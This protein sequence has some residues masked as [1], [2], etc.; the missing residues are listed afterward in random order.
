[1]HSWL[2]NNEH[3]KVE[4]DKHVKGLIRFSKEAIMFG[5]IHD[6][7]RIDDQGNIEALGKKT[8]ASL[9]SD[10]A[11]DCLSKALIWGKVLSRA[12][13]SFTIYSLLGIKP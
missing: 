6:V 9:A 10:D 2:N 13:D 5:V 12:G 7:L 3:L 4:L 11:N 1:M 8:K